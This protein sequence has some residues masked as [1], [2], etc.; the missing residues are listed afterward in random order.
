MP[1]CPPGPDHH[2]DDHQND[3]QHL[4]DADKVDNH[5]S[6]ILQGFQENLRDAIQG[7][8]HQEKISFVR[9]VMMA[10]QKRKENQCDQQCT[11]GFIEE[12]GMQ[13]TIKSFRGKRRYETA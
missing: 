8:F 11:E 9:Q 7:H 5:M 3:G 4:L 1:P 13:K 2:A 12:N 10:A 6:I